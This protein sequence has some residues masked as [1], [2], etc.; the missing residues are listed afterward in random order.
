MRLRRSAMKNN[1]PIYFVIGTRAQFIKVAPIMR[2]MLNAGVQY[3]LIYTAQHRE[4]IDEI[5]NIYGLPPITTRM[6]D[7]GEANTKGSF[8]RW[9]FS[10]LFEVLF[11]PKQYIPRPGFLL[12]HGDT[13]T[14]W[15]AALLGKRAGCKVCHVESGCRSFNIFSPFPEEISRLITFQLSDFFFAQTN[16]LSIT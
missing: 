12:T 1:L 8:V 16:G 10:I 3:A 7:R 2:E 4:N 11:H 15:L 6:Y 5:L 9:F 14:A 13:F